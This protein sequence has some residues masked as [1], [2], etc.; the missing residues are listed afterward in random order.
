MSSS[1]AR[2]NFFRR[3]V[4]RKAY[5]QKSETEFHAYSH[6]RANFHYEIAEDCAERC[7]YCDS[8]EGEVGGREA[9]QIDHF[10]PHGLPEFKHL[11]DDPRNFHHSCG[12]YNNW[13]RAK[14]P[15]V[16]LKL[17]HDDNVGFINPFEED[18]MVHFEVLDDGELR[19][20][21]SVGEYLIRLFALNRPFLRLLRQR[22]IFRALLEDYRQSREA[23]WNAALKG[24]GSLTLEGLAKE[25]A[26]FRRLA[27][28]SFGTF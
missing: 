13:K 5:S 16:D 12:R 11:K 23:E 2:L 10:R 28:L 21:S 3:L 25:F 8:H 14:W 9:M 19:A 26:E 6:Y 4:R 18:R 7:V 20:R 17:C 27:D 22:R 15:C 24:E 1:S